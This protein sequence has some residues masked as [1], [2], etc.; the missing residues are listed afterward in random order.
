MILVLVDNTGVIG[1]TC[2]G[3]Y[4]TVDDSRVGKYTGAKDDIAFHIIYSCIGKGSSANGKIATH[5]CNGFNAVCHGK[6][7]ANAKISGN[8]AVRIIV[9]RARTD[10][11][12]LRMKCTAVTNG[13][14]AQRNCPFKLCSAV[15]A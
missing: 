13:S 2:A 1:N 8:N 7:R 12:I 15:N 9:Q 5:Y 11:E 6:S 14:S 10:S 3:K 4:L